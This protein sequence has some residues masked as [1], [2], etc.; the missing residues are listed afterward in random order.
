MAESLQRIVSLVVSSHFSFG[1]LRTQKAN[2]AYLCLTFVFHFRRVILDTLESCVLFMQ[3]KFKKYF[4]IVKD[5]REI[6]YFCQKRVTT[7]E[8]KCAKNVENL[9]PWGPLFTPLIFEIYKSKNL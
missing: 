4:K 7:A 8:L 6:P 9:V 1:L 5:F 3:D 2:F